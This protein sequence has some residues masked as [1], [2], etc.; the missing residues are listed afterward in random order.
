[1]GIARSTFYDAPS[2]PLG[3]DDLVARI[4]AICDEFE[5]YGY[6]RVGAALRHQGVVVNGKKLRR[7]MREN[8]LQPKRRRCYVITTDSNHAGPI[9]PD[10]AKDV[11]PEQPNQLWVADLTYVAI[12]GGFVYLA[13]IL[14]AWSRKVVGYAISRSMDARIAVAALKAAIRNREPAKGCIHHS[15]RGS[16]YASEVY[17]DLLAAH[18]FRGSM[19]RRGNPYDNAKAESFM[20]TLKVEAVYL[21]AYETFEDVTADLP[22]FIDDVYN[23]KRLHSALG[24]LSPVQFEHQHAQQTV[25]TAA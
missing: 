6:R 15:D 9:Y 20:K 14:D 2:A 24:Y 8:G 1:M 4:G 21:A 11:V 17:R 7:L 25:K 19:S 13:A 16:Q 10:L 3:D 18:K 23:N 12:P 22:R 5:C